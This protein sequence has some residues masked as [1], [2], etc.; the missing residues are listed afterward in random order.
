MKGIKAALQVWVS[1]S[2]RI[3][4]KHNTAPLLT[5]TI[6]IA[7]LQ[8]FQSLSL[9]QTPSRIKPSLMLKE[10]EHA[11]TS[12]YA[13]GE[14]LSKAETRMF[15]LTTILDAPSCFWSSS[16]IPPATSQ[17][18]FP[19]PSPVY[20]APHVTGKTAHPQ[21]AVPLPARVLLANIGQKCS[22]NWTG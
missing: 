7:L 22:W 17:P 5:R 8:V 21:R 15:M 4:S 6:Q 10:G 9:L 19:A 20:K 16:F 14:K 2:S 11:W 1:I 13:Q 18:G 3:I 12:E